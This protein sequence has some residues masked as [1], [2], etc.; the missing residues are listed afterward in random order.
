MSVGYCDMGKERHVAS[1]VTC[2]SCQKQ[3]VPCPFTPLLLAS[4]AH[5]VCDVVEKKPVVRKEPNK[6]EGE[7]GHR[8]QLEFPGAKVRFESMT[9]VLENGHKYRPD[10]IVCFSDGNILCVEVKNGGFK[11][12]S[13]GRSRL[14]FAQARIDWPMFSWRWA[15]KGEGSWSVENF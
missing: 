6:T 13:Y 9:F 12:A 11:H 1:N 10:W 8:L 15:S 7:Y 14:A 2:I 5:S 3:E 4:V